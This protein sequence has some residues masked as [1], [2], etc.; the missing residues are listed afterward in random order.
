MTETE[1]F[2]ASDPHQMLVF[3]RDRVSDRKLRLFA[4]ACSRRIWS[5]I[6][7][8]GRAAVEAAEKFTDGEL[9]PDELRAARL[10][11]KGTGS[12]ASW[13][14][15]AT[16]PE[17]A[18]RNAARSAQAGVA[19]NPTLGTEAGELLAQAGLVRDI[20]GPQSFRQITVDPIWLTPGV[21]QLAGTIYDNRAFDRMP[22]LADALH[23]AGCGNEEIL[24]HCGLLGPHVRGCWVVDF[25]LGKE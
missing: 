8:L 22:E 21:V 13:Y 9:G 12:Q 14:A 17:V 3:L 6:D 11:C 2:S 10:A 5:F 15:A 4:V 20:F 7:D 19:S 1:W 24:R 25:V 16:N 18:A 23:D